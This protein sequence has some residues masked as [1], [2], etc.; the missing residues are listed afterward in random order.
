MSRRDVNLASTWIY[1]LQTS[2]GMWVDKFGYS[3]GAGTWMTARHFMNLGA[4][5]EAIADPNWHNDPD[6]VA[7]CKPVKLRI[8][9][10]IETAKE[11]S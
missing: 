4:A 6:G 10:E 5:R 3:C 11:A 7:R 2:G 9:V 8:H 1:L